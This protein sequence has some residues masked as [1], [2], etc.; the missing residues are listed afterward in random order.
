MGF[1]EPECH[2]YRHRGPVQNPAPIP[3][4]AQV[5]LDPVLQPTRGSLRLLMAEYE[6]GDHSSSGTIH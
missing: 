6:S 3:L 2:R 4:N 5:H 1:L